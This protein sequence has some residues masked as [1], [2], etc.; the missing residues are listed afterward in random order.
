ML[1]VEG[2]IIEQK[3]LEFKLLSANIKLNAKTSSE[4]SAK[5]YV[6]TL[7]DDFS[8]FLCRAIW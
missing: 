2:P 6:W 7:K 8:T 5:L 3:K 1:V 4:K